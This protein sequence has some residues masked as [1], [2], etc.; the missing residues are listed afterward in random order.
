M[1][2]TLGIAVLYTLLAQP[3]V[4]ATMYLD[5][6]SDSLA[7]GDGTVISVRLDTNEEQSECV[8]AIE[9]VL[10]LS[11]PVSAVDTSLGESIFSVWVEPPTISQGGK[12]VTFAG[13]IPNGYCGRIAGDPRLTNNLF[14]VVVRSTPIA[15]NDGEATTGELSFSDQTVA[16]LND[17]FGTTAELQTFPLQL[18]VRPELS[19]DILDPWK[20]RVAADTISPQEF[21]IAFD[22]TS[23]SLRGRYYITFNTTD[24]QTGIDRYEVMEE[25]L[26]QFSS[27]TWGAANVP[28]VE[29]RSPYV[30]EDQTLNSLIRVKA[31]DKAGNEY[32]ATYLPDDS[33]RTTPLTQIALLV[34]LGISVVMLVYGSVVFYK[35]R[36]QPPSKNINSHKDN[37]VTSDPK[38]AASVDESTTSNSHDH[39]TT[40]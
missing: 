25:P 16:Y 39:E 26:S 8:N 37:T 9:G 10:Q 24:K 40:S 21:S 17:G 2:R 12:E 11:G 4:A 14:D 19:T 28:W 18:T 35:R 27:F 3:V 38:S 7:R 23:P 31:I 30:L 13:G 34:L 33:L 15:A 5:S 1:Y 32:I 20:E 29:D 36:Q 22:K 6:S